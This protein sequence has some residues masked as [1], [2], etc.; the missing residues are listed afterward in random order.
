V[1][2]AAPLQRGGLIKR[3]K[4]FLADIRLDEGGEITAHVANP[5]AMTGLAEPGSEV[6]LSRSGD[7][8]RKLPWSW[9]LVRVGEN[10]VVV[11]TLLANRIAGEA[12][13]AGKI[14]ELAFYPEIRREVS[15]GANS[16]VD[17]LLSGDRRPNC[18]VEVKSVTLRQ[19]DS[20]CFPDAVTARGSRHLRELTEK[21]AAGERA[22]MLY[23]VQREDCRGFR[24]ADWIDPAY[25]RLLR[26]AM[27]EGVETLCYACQINTKGIEIGASLPI[28]LDEAV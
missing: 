23:L 26:R 13:A 9:E 3:Y 20:A 4:R 19:G 7:T 17:F 21:A 12:L 6:W 8:K 15:Y 28:T 1:K 22:V 11:N 16:R 5:G 10:L 27:A 2:F 25:G 14:A 24:A 18:Y